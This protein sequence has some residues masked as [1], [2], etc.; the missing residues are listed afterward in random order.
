[1]SEIVVKGRVVGKSLQY[2]SEKNYIVFPLQVTETVEFSMEEEQ[3]KINQLDFIL[4]VCP[5][6][7]WISKEHILEI[8]GTI[9]EGEGFFFIIPTKIYSNFWKFSFTEKFD[10]SLP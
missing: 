3:I 9:Q 10:E 4:I 7:C 2:V 8:T 1:M 6:L 5:F